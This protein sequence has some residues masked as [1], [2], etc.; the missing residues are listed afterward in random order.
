MA[1]TPDRIPTL[2]E[3]RNAIGKVEEAEDAH[4]AIGRWWGHA[5][6]SKSVGLDLPL[7]SDADRGMRNE[8]L[9]M[10]M[11]HRTSKSVSTLL[12]A[13]RVVEG[14]EAYSRTELPRWLQVDYDP[15]PHLVEA[16]RRIDV[17]P[18]S[19]NFQTKMLTALYEDGT[20]SAKIGVGAHK[21]KQIYPPVT[22]L[23]DQG[24]I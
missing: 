16:L 10:D 12:Q 19:L 14:I 18:N 23:A 8:A 7:P 5:L 20:A 24:T 9:I 13:A 1:D 4:Q 3:V 22:E 17:D 2:D 21:W 6:L 11:R 15:K